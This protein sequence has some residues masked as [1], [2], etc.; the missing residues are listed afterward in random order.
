M[1]ADPDQ[2]VRLRLQVVPQH[3]ARDDRARHDLY[4]EFT[5]ALRARIGLSE[6]RRKPVDQDARL[7]VGRDVVEHHST[8]G[9]RP[10]LHARQTTRQDEEVLG[11]RS[12]LRQDH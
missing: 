5:V 11:P 7:N 9:A 8:G 1:L 2:R 6:H 12:R 4:L 10:C 3:A